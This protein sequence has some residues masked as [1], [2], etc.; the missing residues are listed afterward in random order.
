MFLIPRLKPV[1]VFQPEEQKEQ[2]A[3]FTE[4]M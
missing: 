1:A 2:T 4:M 3:F